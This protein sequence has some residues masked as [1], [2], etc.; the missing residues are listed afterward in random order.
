MT[1]ITP[2]INTPA[3]TAAY[4]QANRANW[5][6]WLARDLAS[7]HHQ[8]VAR[9]RTTGSSLRPIERSELGEGVGVAGKSLLHLQCNMGSETLSWARLGAH[10]TGVDISDAAIEMAR[11]LA[12]EVGYASN[13]ARFIRA[14]IYDLPTMLDEQFD[15]VFTSYGALCWL[16]DLNRWAHVVADCLKPGGV[17]YM[18]EMSPLGNLFATRPQGI[19]DPTGLT[20]RVGGPYFHQETPEVERDSDE[21]IYVWS[22][23]LGETLMALLDAG[24]RFDYVHEIPLAHY[25]RF[26][27]LVRGD[28]GYWHWPEPADATTPRNTLPL[29]FSVLARKET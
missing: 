21:A 19:D 1:K 8:D 10:V 7:E 5:N 15:I 20:F 14:D 13:D 25:Q 6:T 12:T 22:Y 23:G 18:V 9:F 29:L 27:A 24:L 17:F 28:D 4:M 3:E 2:P 11:M 16:P 26:P